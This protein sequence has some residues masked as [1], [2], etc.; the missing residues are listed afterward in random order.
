MFKSLADCINSCLILFL[1]LHLMI[2]RKVAWP[3]SHIKEICNTVFDNLRFHLSTSASTSNMAKIEEMERLLREAQA[4]KQRLLEYRVPCQ[5]MIIIL[6]LKSMLQI[7]SQR[8]RN[9]QIISSGS[10]VKWVLR[11]EL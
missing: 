7:V 4:E 6:N 11:S 8:Q 9:K 10:P 1:L 5:E 3:S 2:Y